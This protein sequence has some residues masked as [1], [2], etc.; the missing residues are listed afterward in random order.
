MTHRRSDHN[1]LYLAVTLGLLGGAISILATPV[2][3]V[4]SVYRPTITHAVGWAHLLA[5]IICLSAAAVGTRHLLPHFGY[6]RALAVGAWGCFLNAATVGIYTLGV[7]F[8]GLSP[9]VGCLGAGVTVGLGLLGWKFH[10][11]A[12]E[13]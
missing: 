4:A 3:R 8:T 6:H 13:A 12:M 1:P 10:R 5:V 2:M 7:F 11:E 9:E